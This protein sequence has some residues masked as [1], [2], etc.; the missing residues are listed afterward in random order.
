MS[1]DPAKTRLPAA[2][3]DGLR[4]CAIPS[5][6]AASTLLAELSGDVADEV[7]NLALGG[8]D[9]VG[10]DTPALGPIGDFVALPHIDAVAVAE[11][12]LAFGFGHGSSFRRFSEH[13]PI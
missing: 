6:A 7:A 9:L 3:G 4:T 12:A 1:C 5:R 11:V 8:D 10:A 2:N 13:S